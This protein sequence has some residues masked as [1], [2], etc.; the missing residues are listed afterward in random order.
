MQYVCIS[1]WS[2]AYISVQCYVHLLACQL[3]WSSSLRGG[4]GGW[5]SET[6]ESYIVGES[7][8][9]GGQSGNAI[10]FA[11]SSLLHKIVSGNLIA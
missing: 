3:K 7:R 9:D 2:D 6:E 1:V 5:W 10:C 8:Y 4:E 11:C